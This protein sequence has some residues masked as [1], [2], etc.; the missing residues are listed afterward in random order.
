VNQEFE[1]LIQL[2][3]Y[4][5]MD[6]D[7]LR[8]L[9]SKHLIGSPAEPMVPPDFRL[10]DG[11]DYS[12]REKCWIEWRDNTL[13]EMKDVLWP[14]WNSESRKWS[15]RAVETMVEL[16]RVDLSILLS[17]RVDSVPL[18]LLTAPVSKVRA[19]NC[20][21]H[22]AFFREEDQG[23]IFASYGFYDRKLDAKYPAIFSDVFFAGLAS[24]CSSTQLQFKR[25]FQRPRAYQTAFLLGK[26]E[27]SLEEATSSMTPSMVSGHSLQGLIGVGA[28]MERILEAG[29]SF[30]N[31]SWI[32]LGEYAVDIGDRRV[33]AGVHYPSDNLGSW[34][35]LMRLANRI[36]DSAGEIKKKLWHAIS[37]QSLVYRLILDSEENVYS[38]GLDLLR[39]AVET[40]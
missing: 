28:V 8:N 37:E 23:K 26:Y 29:I 13:S 6:N 9:G 33:M 15:G 3:P 35:V 20:P 11:C 19:L 17:L 16:T 38:A 21:P 34:I 5:I 24:K 32:A 27:F 18:P 36:F 22:S 2:P 10:P 14:V 25:H 4:G 39:R 7:Y 31:D 40:A 1:M 12:Q 30:D